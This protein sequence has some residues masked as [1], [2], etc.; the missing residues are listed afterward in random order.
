MND[1]ELFKEQDEHCIGCGIDLSCIDDDP[2]GD[3]NCVCARCRAEQEHNFNEDP[4]AV[5]S[6]SGSREPDPN[7][8]LDKLYRQLKVLGLDHPTP[9]MLYEL[10]C[11]VECNTLGNPSVVAAQHGLIWR[12]GKVISP[13]ETPLEK[14]DYEY[15]ADD[16][17]EES[18]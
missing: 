12:D 1:D 16:L 13:P 11:D 9:T 4:R 7:D 14:E 15:A 18:I 8:M 6:R 2:N 17:G 10:I 3:Q 5:F